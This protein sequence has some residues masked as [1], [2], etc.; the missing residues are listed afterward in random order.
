MPY[1]ATHRRNLSTPAAKSLMDPTAT[2]LN[3]YSQPT[4]TIHDITTHFSRLYLN[5]KAPSF[6]KPSIHPQAEFTVS[7][8]STSASLTKSQSQRSRRNP[9]YIIEEPEEESIKKPL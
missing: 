4:T 9:H 2:T 1:N 5:N 6:L 3:H 7:H 8:R